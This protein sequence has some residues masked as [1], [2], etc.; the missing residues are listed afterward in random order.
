VIFIDINQR[1]ISF[2]YNRIL[3]IIDL[4]F[5]TANTASAPLETHYYDLRLEPVFKCQKNC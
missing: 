4:R 3:L 2:V 5:D 1:R